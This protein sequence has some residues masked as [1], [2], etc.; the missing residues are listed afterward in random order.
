MAAAKGARK[1]ALTALA[2]GFGRLTLAEF[3]QA[4]R[5]LLR[6]NTSPIEE[7]VICLLLDF[8]VADLARHFPEIEC[9]S[10]TS[11]PSTS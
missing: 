10:E 8:E 2:T 9:V 3:A 4:M 1:V 7:V 5:P 6:E 11:K